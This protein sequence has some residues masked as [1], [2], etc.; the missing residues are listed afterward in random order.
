MTLFPENFKPRSP[1]SRTLH[2][3]PIPDG[4]E[5]LLDPR[6]D[7]TLDAWTRDLRDLLGYKHL[8]YLYARFMGPDGT[9]VSS[10]EK[11]PLWTHLADLLEMQNGT[12]RIYPLGRTSDS[13]DHPLLGLSNLVCEIRQEMATNIENLWTGSLYNK[14]LDYL[15]RFSLR[16]RLAGLRESKYYTTRR[17]AADKKKLDKKD[18]PGSRYTRKQWKDDVEKSQNIFGRELRQSPDGFVDEDRYNQLMSFFYHHASSEPKGA[19]GNLSFED[20]LSRPQLALGMTSALPPHDDLD[21]DDDTAEQ[22]QEH[23]ERQR[24]SGKTTNAFLM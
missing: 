7:E 8:G 17:A 16:F 19:P 15:L 3:S 13:G 20:R 6:P 1:A 12:A 2:I 5:Q 23:E 21:E 18:K 14:A 9:P 22:E 4:L 11:H 24:A 10:S